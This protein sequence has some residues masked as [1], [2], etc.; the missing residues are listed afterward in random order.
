MGNKNKYS[1]DH[2]SLEAFVRALANARLHRSSDLG[3]LD[4]ITRYWKDEAEEWVKELDDQDPKSDPTSFS[5]TQAH[6]LRTALRSNYEEWKETRL[7]QR[8]LHVE[9]LLTTDDWSMAK[10]RQNSA[11]A[12][13]HEIKERGIWLQQVI[14][15]I[16]RRENVNV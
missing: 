8:K 7:E 11:R 14:D 13:D 3:Q 16:N 12:I 9:A 5:T 10:I 15:E 1:H 6:A 2:A 4:S